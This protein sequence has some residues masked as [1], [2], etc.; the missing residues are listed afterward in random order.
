[1]KRF[2]CLSFVVVLGMM[3]FLNTGCMTAGYVAVQLIDAAEKRMAVNPESLEYSEITAEEFAK[4][5]QNEIF[6]DNVKGYKIT[7]VF[8]DS[9]NAGNVSFGIDKNQSLKLDYLN[10]GW[11]YILENNSDFKNQ[12]YKNVFD[13]YRCRN[14][15]E[16]FYC[17]VY[18]YS[19]K[20][21]PVIYKI[22][23]CPDVERIRHEYEEKMKIERE[24]E[25][26][27]I[28]AKL[29]AYEEANKYNPSDFYY[30]AEKFKPAE[31]QEISFFKGVYNGK[32][33]KIGP[34]L[35]GYGYDTY[36][37]VSDVIFVSQ[38]GINI[39]F[40]TADNSITHT[41]QISDSAGLKSGEKV[42][43]YYRI[44]S[45]IDFTVKAIKKM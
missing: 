25:K 1:M 33:M 20:K 12:F 45:P 29:K 30:I 3:A 5:N 32:N 22:E 18:I 41:L 19:E 37:Y 6:L 39:T 35:W 16:D 4:K 36:D 26:A 31:Y 21:V 40:R 11:K 10:N 2:Y 15:E 14:S 34:T 42:K 23:D 43:L 38:N 27:E 24:K 13:F 17:T 28:E 44:N 8:V 9:L 7:G